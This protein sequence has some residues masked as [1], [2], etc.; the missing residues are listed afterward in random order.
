MN[1]VGLMGHRGRNRFFPVGRST[2]LRLHLGGQA[3]GNFG[4]VLL[5]AKAR[6]Q[7]QPIVRQSHLLLHNRRLQ[8]GFSYRKGVGHLYPQLRDQQ[9]NNI[10]ASFPRR[11]ESIMGLLLT[12]VSYFNASP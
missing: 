11:R 10:S 4:S 8:R 3:L 5:D 7:R 2:L 9:L 1:F 6:H 12:S